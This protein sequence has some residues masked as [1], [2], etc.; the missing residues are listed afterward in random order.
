MLGAA[1]SML[2]DGVAYRD[3]DADHFARRDKAKAIRRLVRRLRDL[4]CEVDVKHAA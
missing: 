3:L 1:Y 4:G 2:R